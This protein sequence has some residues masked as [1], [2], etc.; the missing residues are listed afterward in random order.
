MLYQRS[1]TTARLRV[2]NEAP[3]EKNLGSPLQLVSSGPPNSEC[4]TLSPAFREL[5]SAKSIWASLAPTQRHCFYL[6]YIERL[7]PQTITTMLKLE[8][9]STVS[10]TS[11]AERKIRLHLGSVGNFLAIARRFYPMIILPDEAIDGM[12][13]RHTPYHDGRTF[14][15]TIDRDLQKLQ[16]TNHSNYGA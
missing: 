15:S 11:T 8:R 1:T 13:S 4:K 6:K 9:K 2:K 3:S 5:F 14:Q 10:Q 16:T 7:S 12:I